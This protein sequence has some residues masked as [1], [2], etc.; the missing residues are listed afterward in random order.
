[1]FSKC[2]QPVARKDRITSTSSFGVIRY[3]PN[4]NDGASVFQTDLQRNSMKLYGCK[5]LQPVL[6]NKF[7]EIEISLE[8]IGHQ[9]SL[10]ISVVVGFGYEW[11]DETNRG[12]NFS[13]RTENLDFPYRVLKPGQ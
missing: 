11:E 9:S 13:P 3:P 2:L 7:D 5:N 6:C 8:L 4:Y 1:M 10:Q 12:K